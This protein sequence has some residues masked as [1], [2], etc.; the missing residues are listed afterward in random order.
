[1]IKGVIFDMDGVMIDSERQSN[2]GW[3][4]AAKEK[5]IEMPM[6]LIDSFKG[7]PA[8]LSKQYFDDYFKGKLD[9]WETRKRRSDFVHELRKKEGIPVK[10]GLYELLEYI[11]LSG[12][13]CAVATSTQRESAYRTLHIIGAWE[14]LD[15]VVF[16]DEVENGKPA[17]D[18]FLKA[19][20]HM[21]LEPS[22]CIV[23]EDSIN[24]I[25]AG[26]NAKMRVVHVPDTIMIND[27]IRALTSIICEDL[28]QIPAVIE[29][30]NEGDDV[31]AGGETADAMEKIGTVKTVGAN[32]A[33]DSVRDASVDEAVVGVEGAVDVVKTAGGAETIE[34]IAAAACKDKLGYSYGQ[35][36]KENCERY[37]GELENKANC[38]RYLGGLEN[39]ANCER[40]LGGLENKANCERHLDRPAIKRIF[41]EY[42]A[43]YNVQDDK[44][45]LKI[46]HTY[47][48]AAL[49]EQIAKSL[50][51]SA[52]LTSN[53]VDMAWFLGMFHDIGRF[54]QVRRFGTFYDAESI[55]HAAISADITFGGGADNKEEVDKA[56]GNRTIEDNGTEDSF[57]AFIADKVLAATNSSVDMRI[58]EL[59][60]R[61][62]NVYRLP[63]NLTERERM[64]CNILRDADKID[65]LKVCVEEPAEA[66]YGVTGEELKN[67]SVS[68]EVM[69]AFDREETILKALRITPIDKL[70]G[71]ISLVFELV[72]HESLLT[73]VMQGYLDRLLKFPTN[74]EKAQGQLEI[75]RQKMAEYLKR[76]EIRFIP[77]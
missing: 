67:C 73:A 39:K 68:D 42:V 9:Y 57:G 53:D 56:M 4:S 6:W 70:I 63:D 37:L 36:G 25:K 22:E 43:S 74:D 46:E 71:H 47:R 50:V 54:E 52:G 77:T 18:I 13:K 32:E 3:L 15:G 51:K 62:H 40:Y 14:Y 65:I 48:V 59:A 5:G 11:K 45:R 30:W 58:A 27:E 49:C 38:E 76:K 72:Y 10:K 19:A 2:Y 34:E 66:V 31:D 7:A 44:I 35:K 21:N 24:G 23:I 64:F 61:N 33:V 28:S 41:V 69:Q 8:R 16:G 75:I 60:I 55:D 26:Y 17:P 12:L 1:M 20:S 29:E